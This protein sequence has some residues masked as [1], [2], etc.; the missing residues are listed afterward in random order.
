MHGSRLDNVYV[1]NLDHISLLHFSYL[2]A[3]LDNAWLWDHRIGHA[4]M[5]TIHKLVKHDL[6]RGLPCY[7]Y[8]KDHAC[9]AFVKG[10]QVGASF[11]PLKSMFT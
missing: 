4:C 5:C 3:S 2:K 11:K 6:V 9:S 7:K 1:I 10:K 8:E